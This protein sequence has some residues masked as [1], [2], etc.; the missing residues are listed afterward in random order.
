[1][2]IEGEFLKINMR[3]TLKRIALTCFALSILLFATQ[4]TSAQYDTTIKKRLKSPATVTGIIGGESHNSYVIRARKGQTMTVQ[5][6]WKREADN[7]AEFTIS[8][9][10]SF[11]T[12]ES[13]K[14]GKESNKG[15][16]WR[17]KIPTTAN[18]YIYVVAN[19]SAKYVLKVNLKD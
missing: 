17:G 11:F 13:V 2:L 3:I 1:M 14:F 8:Y 7:R 18:Y 6:T 15:K 12:A 5:I 19:P 10:S 4:I 9:S 16:T